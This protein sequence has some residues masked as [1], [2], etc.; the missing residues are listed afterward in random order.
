MSGYD[1]TNDAGY[2]RML[3]AAGLL[4]VIGLAIGGGL[5]IPAWFDASRAEVDA[6]IARL[7]ALAMR[8]TNVRDGHAQSAADLAEIEERLAHAI[9]RVPLAV[10]ES[11]FV[12]EVVS[13]AETHEITLGD[14]ETL[15]T[16]SH[17]THD[18]MDVVIEGNCRYGSLCRLLAGLASSPRAGR[19]TELQVDLVEP[20]SGE[21]SFRLVWR[22]Y[23][24]PGEVALQAAGS[25]L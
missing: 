17:E 5:L 19:V 4:C 23:S 21:L 10:D 9:D 24:R 12:S 8:E 7:E 13:L 11:T 20:R 2:G 15:Q 16:R 14:Y 22:L 18:E 25:R 6:E 3:D 1:N